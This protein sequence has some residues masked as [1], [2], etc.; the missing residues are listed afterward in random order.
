MAPFFQPQKKGPPHFGKALDG[1]IC[2]VSGAYVL[3][4]AASM[5][6]DIAAATLETVPDGTKVIFITSQSYHKWISV[7]LLPLCALR[8]LCGST[9]P[10]PQAPV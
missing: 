6:L 2:S 3:P 4:K 8:E 7:Y 5:R 9:I 10:A 1:S